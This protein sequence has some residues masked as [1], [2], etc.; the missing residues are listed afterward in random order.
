[1]PGFVS[2]EEVDLL[3]WPP[4]GQGLGCGNDKGQG[5]ERSSRTLPVKAVTEQRSSFCQVWALWWQ[6]WCSIGPEYIAGL[7]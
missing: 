7:N 6:W 1:M 4:S 5:R 3:A 2:D